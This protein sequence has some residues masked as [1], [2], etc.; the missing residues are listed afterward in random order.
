[1]G[2]VFIRSVELKTQKAGCKVPTD[3]MKIIVKEPM[4]M[5]LLHNPQ[6]DPLLLTWF[7]FNPSMD[8]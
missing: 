8:K 2:S 5:F 4:H 1:M 7:N 6:Q 3:L